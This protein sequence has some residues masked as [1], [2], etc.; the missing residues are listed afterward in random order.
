LGNAGSA[1]V[2]EARV[3]ISR[4]RSSGRCVFS[5]R[6][7]TRAWRAPPTSAARSFLRLVRARLRSTREALNIGGTLVIP[8]CETA[9]I[10]HA[11]KKA[12]SRLELPYRPPRLPPGGR[13][14]KIAPSMR[15]DNMLE[16]S[17]WI[18]APVRRKPARVHYCRVSGEKTRLRL[19]VEHCFENRRRAS[20]GRQ[21]RSKHL[22]RRAKPSTRSSNAA[23]RS[24]DFCIVA[25]STASHAAGTGPFRGSARQ[26]PAA[27]CFHRAT[28]PSALGARGR[29]S[30]RRQPQSYRSVPAQPPSAFV[31]SFHQNRDAADRPSAGNGRGRSGPR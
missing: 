2:G 7:S 15:L 10:V 4:P 25:S 30:H 31:A 20:S 26:R 9:K 6:P 8:V 12:P 28:S 14:L 16:P 29:R 3:V 27:P 21:L 13:L 11:A 17:P 22:R 19:F 5:C 23:N 24:A 18:A 1:G